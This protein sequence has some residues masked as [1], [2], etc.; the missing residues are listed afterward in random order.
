M[1]HHPTGVIIEKQSAHWEKCGRAHQGKR[2]RKW[3]VPEKVLQ[4]GRYCQSVARVSEE[5]DAGV[6][7]LQGGG[8]LLLHA[9]GTTM[10]GVESGDQV[11]ATVVKR[12]S[13]PGNRTELE[14]DGRGGSMRFKE[15]LVTI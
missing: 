9:T 3:I 8:V 13:F 7:S 14:T 10:W 5:S 12:C 15:V 6:K 4:S 1:L 2:E 11:R